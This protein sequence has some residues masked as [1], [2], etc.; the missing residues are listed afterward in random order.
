MLSVANEITVRAYFSMRD[1][2]RWAT[3]FQE[4][5]SHGWEAGGIEILIWMLRGT[6]CEGD[7]NGGNGLSRSDKAWNLKLF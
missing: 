5:L 1:P 7:G 6:L 3:D 2:R 4:D